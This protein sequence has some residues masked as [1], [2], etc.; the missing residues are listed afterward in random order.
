M[1]AE[2]KNKTIFLERT[3]FKKQQEEHCDTLRK[4][5]DHLRKVEKMK[6]PKMKGKGLYDKEV[7]KPT[8]QEFKLINKKLD[9][10]EK[11][12]DKDGKYYY[13]IF[14]HEGKPKLLSKSHDKE[15]AK[16]KVLA[17]ICGKNKYVGNSVYEVEFV[18]NRNYIDNPS[19]L[20]TGLPLSI[21]IKQFDINNK[22]NLFH[23]T[24]Y[25]NGS[26]WYSN[27]DILNNLFHKADVKKIVDIVKNE[28]IYI[29]SIVKERA[30]NLLEGNFESGNIKPKS[31]KGDNSN[32]INKQIEKVRNTIKK[33]GKY[34]I[35]LINS[36]GVVKFIS[37]GDDKETVIE[38]VSKMIKGKKEYIDNFIYI[39]ELIVNDKYITENHKLVPG[40]VALKI[41]QYQINDKYDLKYKSNFKAGAVWYTNEDLLNGVFH[42][43]DIKKVIKIINDD[44]VDILPVGGIRVADLLNKNFKGGDLKGKQF[45]KVVKNID[46]IQ[47]RIDDKGAY[48][49]YIIHKGKVLLAS[50]D[51]TKKGAYKHLLKRIK[52]KKV[53]I[54]DPVYE[55]YIKLD[56]KYIVNE[57]NL[58]AGPVSLKIYQHHITNKYSLDYEN[59]YK[60][61]AVWYTNEDLLKNTLNI[62]DIKKTH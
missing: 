33:H 49:Y 34:G 15:T 30:V 60:S 4:T 52:D 57:H 1:N 18:I 40:P 47:K 19:K 17:D 55:V 43:D 2:N 36:K 48:L 45:G 22:Y 25:Q 3:K 61:G 26:V 37:K 13:F 38:N 51:Y 23:K 6:Y 62:K 12:I 14:D 31:K 46:K 21:R 32:E 10:I 27:E 7:K 24:G 41:I 44:N 9:K 16:A 59:D 56:R 39:V 11:D 29:L 35:Y 54:N 5:S 58:I 28:N 20:I 53:Y 8:K 42:F 50:R